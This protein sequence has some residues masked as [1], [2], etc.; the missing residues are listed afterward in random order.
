[1]EAL[2]SIPST[3]SFDDQQWHEAVQWFVVVN[4]GT[5]DCLSSTTYELMLTHELGHGLGFGH[6]ADSNA[7]MYA[8]CCNPHNSL[9][10]ACA[11]YLYPLA[12]STPTPTPTATRLR[13]PPPR[14]P[15]PTRRRRRPRLRLRP[16]PPRLPP[17]TRRRPR[18]AAGRIDGDGAGGGSRRW[19]R[20]HLVA[21][22]RR[23]DQPKLE[24]PAAA[25]H[26]SLQRQGQ[27]RGDQDAAGL[28]DPAARGPRVVAVR[29]RR[30][31]GAPFDRGAD[32]GHRAAG[33]GFA[34]VLRKHL[35]QPR[36][37]SSGRRRCIDGRGRHARSLPRRRTAIEHR[38]HRRC[39]RCRGD[40]RPLPWV[41]GDGD[42]RRDAEDRGRRAEAV[43]DRPALPELAARRRADDRAGVAVAA[44]HR[45]CLAGGQRFD[46][47]GG[48]S[49]QGT[50][51]DLG[52]AGGGPYP[53]RGGDLLEFVGGDLERRGNDHHRGSRIPAREDRQLG[54]RASRR[55]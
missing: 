6:V 51:V 19:R 45:L 10:N 13:P 33:G 47:L 44:R 38:R 21:L 7:L 17:P 31:Q 43:V 52:G 9:D 46:R 12:A 37:G 22:R 16:P 15:H 4:N 24:A 55:S 53:G 1:M 5:G 25:L 11:Q 41:G 49:R 18:P 42:R 28:R 32:P 26:L 23:R 39:R 2:G 54:R 50:L 3:Y 34:G 29:G 20:G 8:N 27:L 30:R 35:R 48:L 36:I 14:P 40:F